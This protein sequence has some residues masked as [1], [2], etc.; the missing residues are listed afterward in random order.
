MVNGGVKAYQPNTTT[1]CPPLVQDDELTFIDFTGV[2]IAVVSG[3][4][5]LTS[6]SYLSEISSLTV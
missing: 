2:G 6:A 1:V 3:W 4:W 5:A